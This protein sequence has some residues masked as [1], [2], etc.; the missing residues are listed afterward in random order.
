MKKSVY[1]DG[2]KIR[3][4]EGVGQEDSRLVGVDLVGE[5]RRRPDRTQLLRFGDR[6]VEVTGDELRLQRRHLWSGPAGDVAQSKQTGDG[7]EGDG[8]VGIE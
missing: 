8:V 2:G 1:C 7:L 3:V 4:L 6:T 5:G